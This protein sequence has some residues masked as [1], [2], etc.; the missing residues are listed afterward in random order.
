MLLPHGTKRLR[1]L[2]RA[3]DLI[4]PKMYESVGDLLIH[5]EVL[6]VY[7]ISMTLHLYFQ[8]PAVPRWDHREG[9]WDSLDSAAKRVLVT[10]TNVSL[11]TDATITTTK[12]SACLG[13][14]NLWMKSNW[15][16]LNADKTGKK[17][18]TLWR[19]GQDVSTSYWEYMALMQVASVSKYIHIHLQ[20][21]RT[22]SSFLP[23]KD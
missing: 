7:P 20:F 1:K 16:L 5:L 9:E 19:A 8:H 23:D 14:I 12:G 3:P 4:Y 13:E 15:C 2:I 17:R 18:E 22:P 11:S 21:T 10:P 6:Y